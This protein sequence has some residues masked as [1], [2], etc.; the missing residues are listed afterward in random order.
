MPFGNVQGIEVIEIR[1][2]LS[3]VLD[4]V[5]ER[6][7]D[8]FNSLAHQG[9]RMQMA[10]KRTTTGNSYVDAFT[11]NTRLLNLSLQRLFNASHR[12]RDPRFRL[13]HQLTERSPLVW[14]D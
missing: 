3:I 12:F 8:V 13:L 7:E 9:D 5:A 1:F 2:D 11:L 4:R 10:W 14:G 6:N